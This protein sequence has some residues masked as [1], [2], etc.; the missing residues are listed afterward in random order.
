[1]YIKGTDDDVM[2]VK[3]ESSEEEHKTPETPA[4]QEIVRPQKKARARPSSAA[5]VAEEAAYT[6]TLVPTPP[7]EP[8]LTF[9]TNTS[10]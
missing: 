5:V 1:M 10:K 9:G 2:L 7:A 6:T 8:P 3:G 4:P